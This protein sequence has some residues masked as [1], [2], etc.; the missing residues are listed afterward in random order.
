VV[1]ETALFTPEGVEVTTVAK[2]TSDAIVRDPQQLDR[3]NDGNVKIYAALEPLHLRNN[4]TGEDIE[5]MLRTEP[6]GRLHRIDK[7]K[8]VW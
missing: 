2:F 4:T 8:V 5:V 6:D 1:A 3:T 7:M